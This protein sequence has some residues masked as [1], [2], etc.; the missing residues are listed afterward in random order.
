MFSVTLVYVL[1]LSVGNI[2]EKLLTEFDDW[3][4]VPDHRL[5]LF[6]YHLER[7]SPVI[8]SLSYWSHIIALLMIYRYMISLVNFAFSVGIKLFCH[9]FRRLDI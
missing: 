6:I 5:D 8:L 7:G 4:G 2:N 9:E 3:G 1:L